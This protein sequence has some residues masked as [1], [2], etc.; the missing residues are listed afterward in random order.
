M[1]KKD[2]QFFF[3]PMV[4]SSPSGGGKSTIRAKV[5]KKDKRFK[6][7]VTCTTRNKRKGEV[8]GK[9]YHFVTEK[10]F[11]KLITGK[12]LL[13]WAKVHGNLYGTLIKSVENIL[14]ENRIPLMTIDVKG[15][16]AVKKYFPDA[17]IVF[18]LSPSLKTLIKRLELRKES[19][20]NIAIRLKT[21]KKEI[22]E[23]FFYEYFVVN[24]KIEKAVEDIIKIVDCKCLK[25]KRNREA[26]SKFEK[27]LAS[28][29]GYK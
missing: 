5:F 3:F 20:E 21:A 13:E 17:V 25:M 7:S 8:E 23:A 10:E 6:F 16:K 14:K 1:K 28:Y 12:K 2:N 26:I 19:K 22:K 4:I 29:G 24:G 15:A 9:D 11:K 27:E 18:V